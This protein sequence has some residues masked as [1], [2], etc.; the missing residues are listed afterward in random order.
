VV[1]ERGT[2]VLSLRGAVSARLVFAPGGQVVGRVAGRS[3]RAH[4]PLERRTAAELLN[5][6]LGTPRVLR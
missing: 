2:A 4:L 3:V 6:R 1:L 5:A